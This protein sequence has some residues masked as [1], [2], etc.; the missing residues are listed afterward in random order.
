MIFIIAGWIRYMGIQEQKPGNLPWSLHVSSVGH[1]TTWPMAWTECPEKS[2]GKQ[3]I[4]DHSLDFFYW[5]LQNL[6]K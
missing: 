5:Q 6:E 3:H 1:R 4:I 2:M